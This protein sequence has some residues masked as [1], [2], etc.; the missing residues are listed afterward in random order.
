[1]T[2]T[3]P[4]H[5]ARRSQIYRWHRAH[6]AR[7]VDYDGRCLVADYGD[8]DRERR[9]AHTLAL[10]DLSLTPRVGFKGRGATT[11]L[12]DHLEVMPDAPNRA[13]ALNGGGVVARLSLEEHLILDGVSA[14]TPGVATLTESWKRERPTRTYQ[15]PRADS[16]A[17]FVV[18]GELGAGML[19]KLCSVDLRS[20]VFPGGGVAQTS[21]ARSNAII[22]RRP[23]RDT[24][25]YFLLGDAS[26]AQYHWDCLLDAMVEYDG[27]AVGVEAIRHLDMPSNEEE[28]A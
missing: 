28:N 3:A 7:F 26:S 12:E 22:V 20:T 9:Q 19:A 2:I 5:F 1:M 17:L 6:S 14:A 13:T 18:S 8:V 27:R 21:V 10:C 11:W 24:P 25:C 15:L 4:E 23:C 16:H